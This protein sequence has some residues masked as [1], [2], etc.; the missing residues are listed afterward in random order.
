MTERD[1]TPQTRFGNSDDELL[2]L[3]RCVCGQTFKLWE[4]TLS[5]YADD[6]T[7]MDCCGRRL[8]F[9]NN[10]RILEVTD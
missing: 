5:V 4:L 7:R 6:P 9:S 8:Y 3:T 2:P 1:V 10:V